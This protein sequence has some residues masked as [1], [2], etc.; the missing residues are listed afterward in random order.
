MNVRVGDTVGGGS[1]GGGG[2]NTIA[3]IEKSIKALKELQEQAVIGS[4]EFQRYGAEL[5]RLEAKL[6]SVTGETK[7]LS[8]AEINRRALRATIRFAEGTSGPMGYGTHFGGSYT[9]PGGPHPNKV[10]RAGGYASAAFGA[11]QF[12]PDTWRGAGGGNMTPAR[13]DEAALRLIRNR[14]VNPDEPLT[15]KMIDRLAPEWASFPTLKTGTSYY[16][17]GGKSFSQIQGFYRQQ[18]AK[19]GGDVASIDLKAG[20]AQAEAAEKMREQLK[21]AESTNVA[22]K[23][24]LAIAQTT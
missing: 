17:Q 18:V 8:E 2:A 12:M 16:G 13:Q 20:E 21:A 23:E 1:A 9:A 3:G 24:R 19:G 4:S 7:K 5:Q 14:G 15:D 11:Y 22:L 6:K 10:I